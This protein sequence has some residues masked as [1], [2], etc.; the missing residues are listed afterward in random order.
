MA[1]KGFVHIHIYLHTR[2]PGGRWLLDI[3]CVPAHRWMKA[4]A[5]GLWVEIVELE[6]VFNP[7]L[8]TPLARG[9]PSTG[10]VGYR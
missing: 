1:R 2:E 7:A 8:P 4:W 10:T 9:V 3:W 6:L 5:D